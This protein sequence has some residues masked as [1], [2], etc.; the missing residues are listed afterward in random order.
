MLGLR[1]RNGDLEMTVQ[2]KHEVAVDLITFKMNALQRTL[3]EILTLWKQP[4]A[5]EFVAKVRSGE[6]PDGEL[7]AITV[8]QLLLDLSRLTQ[9]LQQVK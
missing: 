7:D 8:R 1:K 2:L 4:T 5:D 3:D 9:L 6:I